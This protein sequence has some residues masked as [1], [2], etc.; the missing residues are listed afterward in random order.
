VLHDVKSWWLAGIGLLFAFAS[1]IDGFKWD[2]PYPGYGEVAGR[3]NARR[4]E[5]HDL[6]HVWLETLAERRERARA[7]V[8]DIRREIDIM[9]GEIMQASMGRRSFTA[10]FLAHVD[11]LGS[12]ANQLIDT[13]REANRRAR[14][15]RAPRYFGQRWRLTKTEVPVPNE[16]DHK[17]LREQVN[18]ITASLSEALTKIHEMHDRTIADFDRLDTRKPPPVP[19][20]GEQRRRVNEYTPT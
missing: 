14:K 20:P 7:E 15:T 2:D 8:G 3:R 6:K 12:A 17:H 4:E 16:V 1:L 13:Y 5:Y 19:E 9:Q 18:G 11:H 10:A